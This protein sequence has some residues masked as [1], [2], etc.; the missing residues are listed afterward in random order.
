MRLD[1]IQ[2]GF[3]MPTFTDDIAAMRAIK[4]RLSTVFGALSK[5]DTYGGVDVVIAYDESDIPEQ[6]GKPMIL[7]EGT[8]QPSSMSAAKDDFRMVTVTATVMATDANGAQV[9]AANPVSSDEQIN[10]DLQED[11]KN[12]YATWRDLGLLGIDIQT[13]NMTEGEDSQKRPIRKT[14]HTITFNYKR[15]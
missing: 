2:Q 11:I 6:V 4:T 1:W 8:G 12:N 5:Y 3:K 9:G 15:V 14:A 7:L 10:S 13:G